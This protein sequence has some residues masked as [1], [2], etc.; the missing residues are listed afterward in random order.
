MSKRDPKLLLQDIVEA[1]EKI[2]VYTE[3]MDF[4]RFHDDNKTLDAVIRNFE[5]IGEASKQIPENFRDSHPH[6]SWRHLIGLRN[7]IVHAYFGVDHQIIWKI[8]QENLEELK[9]EVI[10][11]IE[12]TA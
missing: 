6:I 11:L 5:V 3:G 10:L 7:R 8:I 1:C 2:Q 12:D 4:K 9:N